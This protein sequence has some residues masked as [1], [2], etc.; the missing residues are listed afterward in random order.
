LVKVSNEGGTMG[1]KILRALAWIALFEIIGYVVGRIITKR[2]TKGDETSDEF[3][4]AAVMGGKK[5]ESHARDL[6]SGTV[7]ASM[8]G[9]ELD[10]RDATL[11]EDGATLDLRTTMGGV[12]VIVPKDWAVE[13]DK[14]SVAGAFDVRVT[15]LQDLP[16]DAPKLH[17]HAVTRLGGG[18]VT[19]KN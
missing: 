14:K 5:F 18:V 10:L 3:Q 2:L 15:P 17:V 11:D 16:E 12:Q 8:G 4:V 6:K 19:T 7:L 9:I 13:V 1:R